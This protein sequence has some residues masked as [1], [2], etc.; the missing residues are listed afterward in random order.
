MLG[1][2]EGSRARPRWGPDGQPSSATR[3]TYDAGIMTTHRAAH[4]RLRNVAVSL[5]AALVLTA[6]GGS[7]DK[8][9]TDSF[10]PMPGVAAPSMPAPMPSP[11]RGNDM[12]GGRGETSAGQPSDGRAIVRTAYLDLIVDDGAVAIAS[13]R[14]LTEARGGH[15][16]TTALSRAEDGTVF[17]SLTLRVP[18]ERLDELVDALDALARAVPIRSIDEYDVTLQLSD[19][20][21]QLE[22]LRAYE[23]ELRALL[24]EVRERDG[25]VEG[26]V[27][28]SDR[29]RSVRTEIDQVEAWRT[30]ITSDV[31]MS[32][33]TVNITPARSTTPVIGTWDLPGVVR[34]AIA[35]TV[36]L[37]QFVVEALVWVALTFVPAL[38][39]LALLIVIVRRARRARRRRRQGVE[40]GNV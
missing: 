39:V 35:A 11:E 40:V 9:S 26:L 3:G 22:N 18:S 31:A 10:E 12:D 29:L 6:C 27:T 5:A 15:V 13:V 34:D 20:G 16:A 14:A 1:R 33:V 23:R 7:D 21:A 30:R 36:R 2:A 4:R 24:T 8:A 32:T 38:V 17:G 37:G 28:I 25:D 19:L